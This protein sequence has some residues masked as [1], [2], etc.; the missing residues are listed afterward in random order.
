[1][2][3][4][5]PGEFG[6]P[7][8]LSLEQLRILIRRRDHGDPVV[9]AAAELLDKLA[10]GASITEIEGLVSRNAELSLRVACV[11]G[12]AAFGGY[13]VKS[14]RHA[15]ELLG[16]EQLQSILATIM[17]LSPIS[18]RNLL[19]G[20][21]K[22]HFQRRSLLLALLSR[23]LAERLNFGDENAHYMAGLLQDCGYIAIAKF[24]PDRMEQVV[25]V[26]QRSEVSDIVDM[27]RYYLGFS[28]AEAGRALSEE[29]NFRAE[30]CQAIGYHH[31]PFDADPKVQAFADLAHLAS[32]MV[33][34]LGLF[35]FEGCPQHDLDKYVLQRLKVEPDQFA[36]V[37]ET[38]KSDTE[39][40][41]RAFVA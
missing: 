12:S 23:K 2:D 9:M 3:L 22:E 25:K 21:T 10:G 14:V 35:I 37:I 26:A 13:E 40:T 31:A 7:R 34:E 32:W 5:Q 41:Y 11:A 28:H 6:T 17:V 27:E 39:Q 30:I 4:R 8:R 36:P 29:Y 15:I 18:K 16:S 38:V 33:N 20:I 19:E 24:V 1:M